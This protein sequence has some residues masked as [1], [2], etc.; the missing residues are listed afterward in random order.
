MSVEP[1]LQGVSGTVEQQAAPLQLAIVGMQH[2]FCRQSIKRTLWRLPG[3]RTVAVN[4]AYEEALI[5][6]DG[7]PPTAACVTEALCSLGHTEFSRFPCQEGLHLECTPAVEHAVV[8]SHPPEVSRVHASMD[9][10]QVSFGCG[11]ID[12][13]LGRGVCSD[14]LV[15]GEPI[16]AFAGETVAAALLAA[17]RREVRRTPRRSAPRGMYCGIGICFDCVM[18]IDGRPNVRTCQTE[19]RPGMRVESQVGEGRW[20]VAV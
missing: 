4:L 14:I 18:T 19:V 5:R 11:R 8:V 9:Q 3:V 20:Q 1:I 6:C 2:S 15:D 16:V 10:N 12:G 17:G 7:A 13:A